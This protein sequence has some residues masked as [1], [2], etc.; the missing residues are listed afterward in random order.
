MKKIKVLISF[1]TRPEA[2]KMAPL[3]LEMQKRTEIN[4]VVCVTGQHEEMLSQV[5]TVFGIKPN[6]NLAIMKQEQTLFDVTSNI[7]MGIKPIFEREKPDIVLVHGDTTTTF[8]VAVAAFYLHVPIGHV[9]AGLRTHDMMSPFPEEYNRQVAGLISR[10]HFAPTTKAQMN[11]LQEGKQ[12]QTIFVTGNT[13]IDALKTTIQADY[14]NPHLAWVGDARLVLLTAHRRENLGEPMKRMFKAIRRIVDE[15][16]DVKVIYPVHLNPQVR[17]VAR[18]VLDGH[19]RIKL[20]DP[21]E[22]VDFHNF[23]DRSYLILTDSGGIQEEAPFLGKPV[24]VLRETT[25]RPEGELAGTLKLVGTHEETIYE[26]TK[27]LLTDNILY[28]NMSEASNPYGDGTASK[29]IADIIINYFNESEQQDMRL[30]FR[31][32]RGQQEREIE[33]A[34]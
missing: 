3:I 24:L 12:P 28:R 26:A 23:L 5:L 17:R 19:P 10:L 7:L 18:E 33:P 34:V 6:Y 27:A 16:E 22:V 25:E 11:L 29:Q 31:H 2:I 30:S 8:A 32:S 4:T 13:G 15:Y 9:E 1:G 14:Q 20:I 21:L